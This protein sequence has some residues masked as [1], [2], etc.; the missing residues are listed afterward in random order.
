MF[1]GRVPKAPM[2]HYLTPKKAH[3]NESVFF[4]IHIIYFRALLGKL[5]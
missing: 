5:N 3:I 1:F 4:K 2:V